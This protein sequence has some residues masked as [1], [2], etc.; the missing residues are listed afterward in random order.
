MEGLQMKYFVLKPKGNDI[1]AKASRAAMFTY[2]NIIRADN[3]KFAL[4]IYK[5]VVDEINLFIEKTIDAEKVDSFDVDTKVDSFFYK[6]KLFKVGDMIEIPFSTPETDRIDNKTGI[7]T[8][9]KNKKRG[10][11]VE[12]KMISKDSDGY[13]FRDL[14]EDAWALDDFV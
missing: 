2:A 5:W 3:P 8:R 4:D 12:I 13:Y 11:L 9:C 1:Y 14:K 7:Y 10:K 6:G